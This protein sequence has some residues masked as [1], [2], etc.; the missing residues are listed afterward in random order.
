MK[1]PH[2]SSRAAIAARCACNLGRTDVT[3]NRFWS[4]GTL[5]YKLLGRYGPV[6]AI[7]TEIYFIDFGDYFCCVFFAVLTILVVKDKSQLVV[8]QCYNG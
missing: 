8:N 1:N 3:L 5:G 2:G 7:I 6:I 4:E